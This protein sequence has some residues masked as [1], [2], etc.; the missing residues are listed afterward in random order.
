MILWILGSIPL[1]HWVPIRKS[2]KQVGAISTSQ[3]WFILRF[4][5]CF[6]L[7]ILFHFKYRLRLVGNAHFSQTTSQ[8]ILWLIAS[9]PSPLYHTELKRWKNRETN[10]TQLT[11]IIFWRKPFRIIHFLQFTA[12]PRKNWLE[13]RSVSINSEITHRLLKN[14]RVLELFIC[15]HPVNKGSMGLSIIHHVLF[16]ILFD[17][18]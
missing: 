8:F 1:T 12:H 18:W 2:L 7:D 11:S 4:M 3:Y 5:Y 13:L 15:L 17:L 10:T 14:F 6:L 9:F 16:Y